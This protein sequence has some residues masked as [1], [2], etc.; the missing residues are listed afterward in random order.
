M[1]GFTLKRDFA[2]SDRKLGR[3]LNFDLKKSCGKFADSTHQRL[4]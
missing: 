4:T 2:R 1:T 3:H